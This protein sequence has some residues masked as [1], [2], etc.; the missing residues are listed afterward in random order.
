MKFV[1]IFALFV[2][3]FCWASS[4]PA[5]HKLPEGGQNY[6][7]LVAGSNT[8]DNYRHQADICHA[9]QD[10]VAHGIPAS[11]IIVMMYDDIANDPENPHKGVV[12]NQP[13]GPDV[14][15]GVNKDYTGDDV[16]PQNFLKVLLG[17]PGLKAQGK[18][19]LESGP[20]D[21]VFIYFADHG[22]T[23]LLGFPNDVLAASDLIATLQK[24]NEKK[25]YN[26]L[27]FYVEACESGSMFENLLP[28]NWS[29]LATTAAERRISIKSLNPHIT[30]QLCKGYF[31]DATTVNECL[32]TFCKSCLVKHLTDHNTCPT[33]EAVIHQR[34]P[35]NYISFDRTMQD[36]VFRLVPNLLK[37]EQER[38]LN[39][40]REKGLPYPGHIGGTLSCGAHSRNQDLRTDGVMACLD[41]NSVHHPQQDETK[42]LLQDPKCAEERPY[43]KNLYSP[44][45]IFSLSIEYHPSKTFSATSGPHV[46][47][48]AFQSD[49]LNPKPSDIPSQRRYLRC[50]GALKIQ[51]IKKWIRLKY[52]LNSQCQVDV[53]FKEIPLL[54]ESSIMD[55]AYISE[56]EKK[57]LSLYYRISNI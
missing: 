7:V 27:V 20:N 54:D 55:L 24:M 35:L 22:G 37:N 28:S 29:M 33:C 52:E 48:R 32:H 46:K 4:L 23:L 44:D 2:S 34:H 45:D 19:V 14:Y 5:L 30:C 40:Y 43:F 26:K 36:L 18:K 11:N 42:A 25:N 10:L 9:F 47:R 50:K 1:S 16:T 56:L 3:C 38:E 6:A 13:N 39:F 53:L 57:P 17:D 12:I 51:Q 31:I 15:H 41:K 49:D 8:Y 21:N